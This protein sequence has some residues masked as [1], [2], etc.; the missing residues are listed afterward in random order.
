MCG[1]SQFILYYIDVVERGVTFLAHPVHAVYVGS[2]CWRND[3]Q[4]T[5]STARAPTNRSE[6]FHTC[7]WHFSLISATHS[8]TGF[9]AL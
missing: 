2:R 3:M 8:E 1:I 6:K 9:V 5:G 7:N 4:P